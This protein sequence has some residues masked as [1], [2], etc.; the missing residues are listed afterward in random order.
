MNLINVTEAAIIE[1]KRIAT[2]EKKDSKV[3][4]YLQG[5]GCSGY[6][7][8]MN[9]TQYPPDEEFDLTFEQDGITFI[10]DVKSAALIKGASLDFGGDLLDRGFKWDF[11]SSTGGCGCGVSFSF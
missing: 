10:V 9:F 3:R 1:L 4:A 8:R 5:G 2:E 6:T 11:P 7:I